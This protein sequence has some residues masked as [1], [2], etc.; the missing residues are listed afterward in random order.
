MSY[1]KK[2]AKNIDKIAGKDIRL[3]ILK[4]CENL[5]S[6]M[7]KE[8]RAE[9]MK[10][11]MERMEKLLDEDD[12]IKIREA[13]ACKPRKF[14]KE[15]KKFYSNSKN[16]EDF[17][18]K[19]E[20]AGYAGRPLVLKNNIVYGRFGIDKCVCGMVGETKNEIPFSWC[21]CCEAHIR[22]LYEKTLKKE[23]EVELLESIISGGND[24]K[25]KAYLN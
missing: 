20:K 7:K 2:F 16:M 11:A 3:K 12:I 6:K 24:C 1:V 5:T 4:G 9:Y 10:T 18:I 19:L 15:S 13:C 23:V 22:W 21:Y 25:Y 8:K 14:L 17:I